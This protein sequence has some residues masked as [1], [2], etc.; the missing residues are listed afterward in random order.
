MNEGCGVSFLIHGPSKA[1]KS[2]LGDSAPEPRLILDSEGNTRFLK[3]R[4]T[5]WNPTQ[6]PPPV[7]G[8]DIDG[9]EKNWN[10]CIAYVRDFST[11]SYAYQWLASGKHP[12][13]SV[14]ID[15]ISESQQRCID[16]IVGD[17]QM[18]IQQWGELLRKMSSLVR[19]YRDLLVHPTN[20][21]SCVVFTAMTKID[22]SG[23]SVPFVQGQLATSLPYYIDCIGY[24][25][26]NINESNE[27]TNYLLMKPH[28]LFE[29]GDRTGVFPT[30]ITNPN[31]TDMIAM[32]CGGEEI[33][34][35]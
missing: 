4:K 5:L 35:N 31:L 23:K 10:T 12:F 29:A 34:P 11:I 22:K 20:P 1:G 8:K 7:V 32:V 24:L 9:N 15:S 27:F 17:E 6:G 33:N 21:L 14:M 3:S 13:K 19:Q 30:I 28:D 26:A 2:F 16:A 25:K 18:K